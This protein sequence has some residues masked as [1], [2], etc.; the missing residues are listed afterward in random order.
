[1]LK[2]IHNGPYKVLANLFL[3]SLFSIL[4]TNIFDY[5]HYNKLSICF[6]VLFKYYYFQ[7]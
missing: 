4:P 5:M 3:K 6:S 7:S 1:M 2:T